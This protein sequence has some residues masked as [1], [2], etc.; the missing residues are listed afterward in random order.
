M[1]WAALSQ[2]K[3]RFLA[4]HGD[5]LGVPGFRL[6]WALISRADYENRLLLTQSGLGRDLKMAPSGISR[7]M[8][9]LLVLDLIEKRDGYYLLSPEVAWKGSGRNHIEALK[10]WRE[11]RSERMAAVAA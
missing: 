2:D 5:E 9:K 11:R 6:L 1:E 8:R 10:E 3:S 4:D 7:A